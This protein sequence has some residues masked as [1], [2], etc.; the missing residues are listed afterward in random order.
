MMT[1]RLVFRGPHPGRTR[2]QEVA[3]GLRKS[4]GSKAFNRA[5]ILKLV[6]SHVNNGNYD[7]E[8][9]Y[10]VFGTPSVW[11]MIIDL[12]E[13]DSERENR[14]LEGTVE[15]LASDAKVHAG[16]VQA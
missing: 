12:T 2:S 6:L 5:E 16:R 7:F 1:H 9:R 11:D 14:F 13:P 10:S 8:G 4:G 3:Y 15:K